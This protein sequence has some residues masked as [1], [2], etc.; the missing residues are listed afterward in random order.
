MI[1]A[2]LGNPGAEYEN[3]RHNLGFQVVTELARSMGWT[4]KTDRKWASQIAKGQLGG[5]AIVLM[6][7]LTYM[8]ESGRAV[9]GYLNYHQL[10]PENL[11]VVSDDIALPFGALRLRKKGS[12]GG[13]NGLYSIQVHI[14]TDHYIRLRMGI[15][16]KHENSNLAD[17]V[18]SNFTEDERK[19]LPEFILKGAAVLK[20]LLTEPFADVMNR[21]DTKV[22]LQTTKGQEN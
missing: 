16:K 18:L 21:I 19:I 8:N 17:Y 20:S 13:H 5:K 1:I 15:G 10:G 11:I 2:G 14:G 4:F 3:T 9:E 6:L 22:N 12:P 7:P